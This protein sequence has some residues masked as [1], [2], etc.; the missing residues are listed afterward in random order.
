MLIVRCIEPST[1]G[2]EGDVIVFNYINHTETDIPIVHR[3]TRVYI[4]NETDDYWFSTKGDNPISNNGFIIPLIFC[5][6]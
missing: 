5:S 1:I 6:N 2:G 4:D 3:V